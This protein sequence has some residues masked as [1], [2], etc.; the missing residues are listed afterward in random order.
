MNLQAMVGCEGSLDD[1]HRLLSHK[2]Y[3]DVLELAHWHIDSGETVN[4][5]EGPVPSLVPARHPVIMCLTFSY[6]QYEQQGVRFKLCNIKRFN[7]KMV[8]HKSIINFP[9]N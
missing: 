5:N 9:L 2:D 8:Y 3:A 6:Y 4:N 7:N 1:T